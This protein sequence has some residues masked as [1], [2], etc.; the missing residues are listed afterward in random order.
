M[1]RY[2][3]CCTLAQEKWVGLSEA[4]SLA[5]AKIPGLSENDA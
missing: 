5:W 3:H 1:E 2:N 4:G